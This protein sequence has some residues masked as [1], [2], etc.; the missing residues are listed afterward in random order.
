MYFWWNPEWGHVHLVDFTLQTPSDPPSKPFRIYYTNCRILPTDFSYPNKVTSAKLL[1]SR[2]QR[3][4]SRISLTHYEPLSYCISKLV[5]QKD[6]PAWNT[7]YIK[8]WLGG[9]YSRIS[10]IG[11]RCLLQYLVLVLLNI[12]YSHAC[13]TLAQSYHR[14]NSYARANAC[15]PIQLYSCPAIQV[16]HAYRRPT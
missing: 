14:V 5:I 7:Q 4:L 1:Y 16:F 9:C 2:L 11:C 6:T 12:S 15:T 10:C 13:L 3:G 8:T